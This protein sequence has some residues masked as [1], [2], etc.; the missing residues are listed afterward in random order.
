[1]ADRAPAVAG[2]GG[3]CDGR[4]GPAGNRQSKELQ[5]REGAGLRR[6]TRRMEASLRAN[7][8]L[9]H[10]LI[11]CAGSRKYEGIP[12]TVRTVIVPDRAQ[13]TPS[14]MEMLDGFVRHG[15]KVLAMGRGMGLAGTEEPN[16]AA[17]MLDFTTLATC[18]GRDLFVCGEVEKRKPRIAGAAPGRKR[19][20]GGTAA[21]GIRADGRRNA[22]VHPQPRRKRYGVR[23]RRDGI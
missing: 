14:D 13:L 17:P 22:G 16:R 15:G 10:R 3:G 19:D 23:V 1:M 9:P 11:N 12:Q 7:G 6:R 18:A 8:Y 21:L 2:R 20:L 4:R 5:W